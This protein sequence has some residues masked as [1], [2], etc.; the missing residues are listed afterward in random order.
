MVRIP[1][2]VPGLARG[3]FRGTRALRDGVLTRHELFGPG[4]KRLL[5]DVYVRADL[6]VDHAVLA[7]AALTL[8]PAAVVTGPSAAWLWD[9]DV[10]GPD[11]AAGS[12]V[13][14]VTVPPGPHRRVPGLRVRRRALDPA[15]VLQ[16]PWLGGLAM[17]DPTWTALD[18]AS[19]PGR[20]HV[21]S[22]V[23]LD[24][25][26][27][28]GRATL[29]GMR[30]LGRSW[31]G[32]G[33]VGLAAAL[34]AADGLAG[35]PP[36]TR[37]R[38]ALLACGLPAPVAQFVLRTASGRRVKALDLAWPHLCF[39]VEYDG[40]N[41]VATSTRPE[42]AFGLPKDRRVLNEAQELG[43]RLHYVT[44][45]DGRDMV[46]AAARIARALS[47]RAVELGVPLHP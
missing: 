13:V 17:T 42:S 22:V 28:S 38:L 40:S 32:R 46:A 43:W 18:L 33:C 6:P 11:G 3:P 21:D 30:D 15:R 35:S 12:T 20:G 16:V 9:V 23:V 5:P 2:V 1:R 24:Q 45:P 47:A 34:A 39:G 7:A 44:A 10:D 37:L 41:H 19:D 27:A 14:E 25:F 36:E 8:L 29:D 4:W 26:A 31:S